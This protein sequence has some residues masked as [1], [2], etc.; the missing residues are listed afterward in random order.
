M[1]K[2]QCYKLVLLVNK[3][4]AHLQQLRDYRVYSEKKLQGAHDDLV[5]ALAA[6]Q[7]IFLNNTCPILPPERPEPMEQELLSH[8]PIEPIATAPHKTIY[9]ETSTVQE[10]NIQIDKIKEKLLLVISKI[11]L[12]RI[13]DLSQLTN[14]KFP[15]ELVAFLDTYFCPVEFHK[16]NDNLVFK[17][18]AFQ[19]DNTENS[20]VI[21][22]RGVTVNIGSYSCNGFFLQNSLFTFRRGLMY[23]PSKLRKLLPNAT[24]FPQIFSE[25]F[26][27]LPLRELFV[28]DKTGLLIEL[29]RR[30]QMYKVIRRGNFKEV[31]K[32][33]RTKSKQDQCCVLEI[34]TAMHRR[35]VVT[36]ICKKIPAI[37]ECWEGIPE[38]V[39]D[40]SRDSN[41]DAGFRGESQALVHLP[42]KIQE[43]LRKMIAREK[44]HGDSTEK[45]ELFKDTLLKFPWSSPERINIDWKHLDDIFAKRVYGHE[46]AKQQ[47]RRI[48]V[49]WKRNQNINQTGMALGLCGPPGV[50][51]THFVSCLGEALGI[52]L[53]PFHLGGQNDA[54][55]LIGHGYTYSSARPGKLVQGLAEA[56][57]RRSILFFD[58]LD[59]ASG[60]QILN[61][62]VHLTDQT[63]NSHFQD[64]FFA[65]IDFDFSDCLIVFSYN[66]R[67]SIDPILLDRI[68]EINVDAYTPKQ[69]V[70][71][72]QR[73]V[74]PELED[75][76][77][78]DTK[79]LTG[80]VIKKIIL[81]Y[82]REAGIR[83]LKQHLETLCCE[84]AYHDECGTK[85]PTLRKLLMLLGSSY[86]FTELKPGTVHGLYA[87]RYG[88]GGVT[89]IQIVKAKK[90]KLTGRL[91][92]TMK[93]S[94]SVAEQVA[95][96]KLG[97]KSPQSY[98]LH[99]PSAG[100]PKDGPSAGLAITLALYFHGSKVDTP[101]KD[102]AC[103]GEI[104]IHGNVTKIGGV[105]A[106][107]T[108]ALNAGLKTVIFPEQN[109]EEY[110]RV[111]SKKL[112]KLDVKF[113]KNFEE[114]LEVFK[115]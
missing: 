59:K 17:V 89:P 86:T 93:E 36:R 83:A 29:E 47:I 102:I 52:P 79:W 44:S 2:S 23:L 9:A 105:A 61:V 45:S 95:A 99:V 80:A 30:N 41:F 71:L 103:T 92:E 69:K 113:V 5:D 94:V 46:T 78:V 50:G 22:K 1:W 32:F 73:F 77:K 15:T 97:L 38:V 115:N 111:F 108:G 60:D 88:V 76:L 106:K 58:E 14:E 6:L 74:L 39:P 53:I 64:R 43:I 48:L 104:D 40:M 82:T 56:G 84:C 3:E 34:L 67:D 42:T 57:T 112:P 54:E 66:S 33:V 90:R 68:H 101:R 81:G 62:L 28:L 31:C 87:T 49:K 35:D 21:T 16:S 19:G 25:V 27:S 11:G 12:S 37:R 85:R 51:K 20:F 65:G 91:G 72:A 109:R 110:K 13:S 10:I 100:T 24:D 114:A 98:H 7:D 26:A 63:T 4:L 75:T 107:V 55:Q 18:T 96:N 70:E 8:L